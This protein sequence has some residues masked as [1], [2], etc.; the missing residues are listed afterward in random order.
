MILSQIRR[1]W[2]TELGCLNGEFKG[3][4]NET[5]VSLQ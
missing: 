2:G 4:Y 5:A 1:L 3:M